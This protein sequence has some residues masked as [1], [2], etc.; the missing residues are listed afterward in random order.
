M[1][2]TLGN[3]MKEQ[4]E[5]RTRFLLPRRTYTVI[6]V[7]G[8]AFHTLTRDFDRPFDKDLE[9]I[10]DWTATRLCEEIQ[11]AKFAYVQSD[12]ISILLTDFETDQT[13]AWFD[14]NLQKMASVS[15]SIATGEFNKGIMISSLGYDGQSKFLAGSK[16]LKVAYFD[17][18]VFTIPDAVEVENY[19]IWR[20]N[21]A[22]RN[23]IQMAARAVYGHGECANKN[24]SQLQD[25]LHVKGIN[26]NDYPTGQKRGRII[27]KETYV[28]DSQIGLYIHKVERT[29]WASFNGK[30]NDYE[31]PIF[32]QDRTFLR[33]LIP[34][35]QGFSSEEH[36]CIVENAGSETD[37][38]V[39]CKIKE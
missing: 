2:D 18:R 14:G 19:F 12:E 9:T 25:M 13:C 33:K 17:S 15:A 21:D 35:L 23:S 30:N 36:T 27:K 6:R 1:H 29:R 24:T 37:C 26:W 20:Q 32:T 34:I 8:K 31:I 3:R 11:G 4:Y 7:D 5:D 38:P 39:C 28:A 10:M 22:S 16:G